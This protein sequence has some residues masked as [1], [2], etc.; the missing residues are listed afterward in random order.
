M[1][2][3]KRKKC[4]ALQ[5]LTPDQESIIQEWESDLKS[6]EEEWLDLSDCPST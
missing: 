2:K 4:P 5:K 1:E 6:L 3:P